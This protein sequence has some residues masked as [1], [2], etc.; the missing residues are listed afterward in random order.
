MCHSGTSSDQLSVNNKEVSLL[1]LVAW[2]EPEGYSTLSV[3]FTTKLLF[4]F[5]YLKIC[6]CYSFEILHRDGKAA[7]PQGRIVPET[8][9][10]N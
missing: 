2:A 10:T 5:N 9:T 7:F 3:Y 1:T 4:K 8:R 6:T